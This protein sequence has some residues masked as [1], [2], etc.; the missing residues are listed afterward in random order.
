MLEFF[1]GQRRKLSIDAWQPLRNEQDERRI[2][3]DLLMELTGQPYLAMPTFI[4]PS[5]EK[6][7]CEGSAVKDTDLLTQIDDVTLELYATDMSGPLE[8]DWGIGLDEAEAEARERKRKLLLTRCT[9]RNFK[10][11]R[12]NRGEAALVAVKFSVTTRST[13][14][15]AAWAHD[16]NG[17][18]LWCEFSIDPSPGQTKIDSQ[19]KLPLAGASILP[20]QAPPASSV[21]FAERDRCPFPACV[22]NAEHGGDHEDAFGEK[23]GTLQ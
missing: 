9:L 3:F 1:P 16:F 11:V 12:I 20:E 6:M 18:T 10:L 4:A 19:E 14:G 23:L 2:R 5:Y 17:K 15:L 13:R 8:V 7:E 21:P 22:K